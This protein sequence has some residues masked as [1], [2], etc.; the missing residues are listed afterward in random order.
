MTL[1]IS[2][3]TS[4]RMVRILRDDVWKD[5]LVMQRMLEEVIRREAKADQFKRLRP[6]LARR[7]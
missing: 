2:P 7:A 5:D 3:G 6:R 1:P 4:F